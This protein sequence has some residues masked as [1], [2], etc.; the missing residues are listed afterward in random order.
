VFPAQTAS[1]PSFAVIRHPVER[2]L[3][4]YAF[5]RDGGTDLMACDR[6]DRRRMGDLSSIDRIVDRLHAERD[7]LAS[8]PSAF[9]SQCCYVLGDDE[10]VMVDRLFSLDKVRGFPA[11][12][13][14]WLGC[15]KLPHINATRSNGATL[16]EASRRKLGEIYAND[17]ALYRTLLAA[18]GCVDAKN[19]KLPGVGFAGGRPAPESMDATPP[20]R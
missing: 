11:E 2:F 7:N 3:S 14:R 20:T 16:S 19:E 13:E 18:G 9:H 6:H 12:L 17:F 4:A 5:L 8:L 1:L 10:A 15:P